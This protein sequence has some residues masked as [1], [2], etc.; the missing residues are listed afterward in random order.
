MIRSRG[1]AARII[2]APGALRWA[3][4]IAPSHGGSLPHPCYRQGHQGQGRW[5]EGGAEGRATDARADPRRYAG[6]DVYWCP[7]GAVAPASNSSYGTTTAA[8]LSRP[9]RRSASASLVAASG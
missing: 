3:G 1:T 6:T 9:S 8:P 2:R 5:P 7:A 4:P